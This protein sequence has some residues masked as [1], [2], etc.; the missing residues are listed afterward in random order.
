MAGGTGTSGVL[1]TAQVYDPATGTWS[2]TRPLSQVRHQHTAALLPDG[3]VLIAGG[4]NASASLATAEL[5]DPPSGTWALTHPLAEARRGHTMTQL[6]D[7]Q[8]LVV[9]GES[10][11]T[12]YLATGTV[13]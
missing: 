7:G 11:T 6:L 13:Y 2:N 10:P 4:R 5:Y 1:A 12:P 3:R 8:V 9:G